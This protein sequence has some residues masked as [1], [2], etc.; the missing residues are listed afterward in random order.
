MYFIIVVLSWMSFPLLSLRIIICKGAFP[1]ALWIL[2][3]WVQVL[4]FITSFILFF[5][6]LDRLAIVSSFFKSD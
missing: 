4:L 3:H 1:F 6:Y 5:K 2:F